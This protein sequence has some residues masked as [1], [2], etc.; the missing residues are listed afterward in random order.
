M[1]VK[2]P[3][4]QIGQYKH[5]ISVEESSLRW[6]WMYWF[7]P[8]LIFAAS[9]FF[10]WHWLIKSASAIAS[11]SGAIH[12]VNDLSRLRLYEERVAELEERSKP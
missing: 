12:H 6:A 1:S 2:D 9:I 4:R 10:D 8:L 3:R 7:L 5:L 11:V